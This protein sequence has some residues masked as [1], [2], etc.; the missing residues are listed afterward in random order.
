VARGYVVVFLGPKG[1]VKTTTIRLLTGALAPTE[2]TVHV[3]GHDV[4]V[5]PARV[6]ERVGYLPEAPPL[7][8]DMT[9]RQYVYY[10][11]QLKGLKR[12]EE[13]VDKTLARL[14]LQAVAQRIVGRLSK[15]VR[16]RV[17]LAQAIVHDPRLLVLDEPSSGLDPAQRVE[18][19]LLLKSL[20]AGD[21][22]VLLSSHILSEVEAVCDRVLI[23]HEGRLVG[24]ESIAS[25][26]ETSSIRVQVRRPED[27][28]ASR[29]AQVDGVIDVR[30]VGEGRFV[31]ASSM[32]VRETVAEVLAPHG[33]LELAQH[34]ALEERYLA[35]TQRRGST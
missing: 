2:G 3:D 29:L 12:P 10:C 8:L 33:L 15:G 1:A 30:D 7:Y 13:A 4:R 31:V 24:E 6:K 19:R 34:R 21:T 28:L 26:G 22:T 20:A 25:L 17:G 5:R 35:A 32:D 14:D 11:G 27:S 23:V 9:V 16:Q 18:F